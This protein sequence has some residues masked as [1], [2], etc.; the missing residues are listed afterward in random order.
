MPKNHWLVAKRLFHILINNP[1]F[2]FKRIFLELKYFILPIPKVAIVEK[3]NGVSFN[4]DFN[5]SGEIKLRAPGYR[6]FIQYRGVY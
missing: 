2:F 6:S 3:V 5:Y 4:F 1:I